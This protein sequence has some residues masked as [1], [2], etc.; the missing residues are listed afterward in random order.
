[1]PESPSPGAEASG[2][3]APRNQLPE[4][5]RSRPGLSLTNVIVIVALLGGSALVSRTPF[6]QKSFLA[7]EP[8]ADTATPPSSDADMLM[9]QGVAEAGEVAAP[10]DTLLESEPAAPQSWRYRVRGEPTGYCHYDQLLN[11]TRHGE[12]RV[13]AC[14]S[15]FHSGK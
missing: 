3:R 7:R 10:V 12:L 9:P 14:L 11:M 2:G 5:L 15:V 6:V 13:S 8:L 4:W 1:M